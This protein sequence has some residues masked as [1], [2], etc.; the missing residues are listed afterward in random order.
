MPAIVTLVN[1]RA[2]RLAGEG[3]LLS[4]LRARRTGMRVIETSSIDE[5]AQATADIARDPPRTIVIAG[6]DGSYMAGVTAVVNAWAD[7][8][9]QEE[10]LPAFA[11]APGGTVSTIARNWGFRGDRIRY[12]SRLLDAVTN[13]ATNAPPTTPRPTLRVREMGEERQTERVGFIV[14]AGL[15]SSFFEVYE[16]EGAG[17]YGGAASIVARVFAGSFA[18]GKLAKKILGPVPC[19][20]EVDGEPTP[21]ERTSLFCASVVRDMGLGLEVVHRAAEETDRFHVVATSLGPSLLGPQLPIVW[22]G[23]PLLGGTRNVDT[24]ARDVVLRFESDDA[25]YVL[26][27]ELLRARAIRVTAGPVIRVASI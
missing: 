2:R 6:G 4:A 18:G 17:G 3:P 1:R 14:G 24:L 10:D 8:G 21:L 16:R 7:A 15:V 26:D 23:R 25:P 22:M 12:T 13:G 20:L 11:L 19:K 27:G 5:L 9:R